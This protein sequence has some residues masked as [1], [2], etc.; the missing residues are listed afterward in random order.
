MRVYVIFMISVVCIV[1]TVS[2]IVAAG[3]DKPA[4][5]DLR[6]TVSMDDESYSLQPSIA[7]GRDS[8]RGRFS[9]KVMERMNR[10]KELNKSLD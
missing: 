6:R 9:D 10:L 7:S 4:Q 3:G 1:L 2:L 5:C 8:F